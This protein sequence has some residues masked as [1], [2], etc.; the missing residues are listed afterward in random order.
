MIESQSETRSSDDEHLSSSGS[1]PDECNSETKTFCEAR[2][3]QIIAD[4]NARGLSTAETLA[5]LSLLCEKLQIEEEPKKEA[6]EEITSDKG[7][8]DN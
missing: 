8:R 7:L 1:Q 6:M 3:L 2:L 4:G 5:A